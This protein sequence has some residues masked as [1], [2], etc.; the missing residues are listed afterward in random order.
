MPIPGLILSNTFRTGIVGLT[1]TLAA[2]FAPYNILVNTVAPGRIATERVAFLDK[3]N[4]EKLG[5]SQEEMEERM[6]SAI[7]LNRYGTPEEFANAVVFLLSEAN[8]YITGQSLIVDGGM[9]R[10]I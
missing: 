2:E 8:S 3:I 7:P 10:A 4:A 1:K 9:V 5:I 6:K